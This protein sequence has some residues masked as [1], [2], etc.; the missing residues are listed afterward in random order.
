MWQKQIEW[1]ILK[2]RLIGNII[3]F[4]GLF[5]S[6][7]SKAA[8]G[9]ITGLYIETNGWQLVLTVQGKSTNGTY[10]FGIT[11]VSNYFTPTNP[12]VSL[13]YTKQGFLTNAVATTYNKTN[14][15]T[16][17]QRK[18]Y[19]DTSAKDEVLSGTNV[20]LRL[21]LEGFVFAGDSNITANILGGFY[22][23]GG[24]SNNPVAGITV[25]NLSTLTYPKPI[26]NWSEYPFKLF[27]NTNTAV[28]PLVAFSHE[29]ENGQPFL[30]VHFWALDQSNDSSPTNIITQATIRSV[31]DALPIV[32][33]VGNIDISSLT[34]GDTLT[35]HARV[36]PKYGDL[37]AI[38]DSSDG[39]FSFPA[40]E[41]AP[42]KIV[43][44]RTGA[45]GRTVAVVATNGN[46]VT[47]VVVAIGSFNT[48][49]PPNAFATVRGA[50]SAAILTNFLLYSRADIGG[51]SI[52]VR[53]GNYAWAGGTLVFT[54]APATW[55][56][57]D[58][59]PGESPIFNSASGTRNLGDKTLIGNVIFSSTTTATIDDIGYLAF[60]GTTFTNVTDTRLIDNATNVYVTRSLV[61]SLPQGLLPSSISYNSNFRLARGNTLNLDNEVIWPT[62]VI[63]NS[64]FTNATGAVKIDASV[65]ES[66]TT[67]EHPSYPIMAFNALLGQNQGSGGH[68]V[69]LWDPTSKYKNTNGFAIVQ[70]IVETINGNVNGPRNF[71]FASSSDQTPDTNA[72]TRA[73]IWH[74]T[75][76]GQRANLLENA[77]GNVESEWINAQRELHSMLNNMFEQAATKNDRNYFPATNSLRTGQWSFGHGVGSSGNIDLDPNGMDNGDW[78]FDFYGLKSYPTTNSANPGIFAWPKFIDRKASNSDGVNTAG[79]G[80]YRLQDD[81][82]LIGLPLRWVLSYDL[83]GNPRTSTRN[84]SGAFTSPIADPTDFIYVAITGNDSTGNGSISLP[85]RTV[86]K[87]VDVAIAGKTV[88]VLPGNY[89]EYVVTKASGTTNSPI[90]ITSQN[91]YAARVKQ[92][93]INNHQYITISGFQVATPSD[94]NVAHIRVEPSAHNFV[95]T[96]NLIG[97][98]AYILTTQT[99][100]HSGS[101]AVVVAD[102]NFTTAGFNP[103]SLLFLGSSGLSPYWFTNHDTART[104]TSISTDGK[105]AVVSGTI[106]N[107]PGSN[108]WSFLYPGSNNDGYSGI[109][110]VPGSGIAAP[111]NGLIVNNVLTNIAGAAIRGTGDNILITGN[112]ITKIPSFY[113]LVWNGRNS[114]ISSNTW[115]QNHNV[116]YYT[117]AELNQLVHPEGGEWF[118][119]QVSHLSSYTGDA[120]TNNLFYRNWVEDIENQLGITQYSSTTNFGY[121]VR[122]NVFIGSASQWSISRNNFELNGNIFIRGGYDEGRSTAAAFGGTGLQIQTGVIITN[123][124]FVNI[125]DH[126]NTN[127]EGS[128]SIV[129]AT[130]HVITNN[131]ATA[132]E[133]MGYNG[134]NYGAVSNWF[135]VNGGDPLFYNIRNPLGEDGLPFTDDDGIRV[136]PGSPL[137]LLSVGAMSPY[138]TTNYFPISHFKVTS[139]VTWQ[140]LTGTNYNLVWA[141]NAPFLRASPIRPYTTPEALGAVP[142]T[143][144]FNASN[145]F[146][147]LLTLT[148]AYGIAYYNWQFGDGASAVTASPVV[149]HTYLTTGE[150][151]VTLTVTNLY[152]NISSSSN[153]YR[154]LPKVV[155]NNVYFVSTV[156]NDTNPGTFVSPFRTI[157]RAQDVVEPGG[158]VGV[159]AGSYGEDTDFDKVASNTNRITFVSL[160]AKTS[161]AQFRQP[162]YTWEGFEMDGTNAAFSG[163]IYL[164]QTCDDTIIRNCVITGLTNVTPVIFAQPS[165]SVLPQDGQ[166]NCIIE[167]NYLSDNKGVQF[168]IQGLNSI[169]RGNIVKNTSGEGDFVR[170]WGMG[171][172]IQGNYATNLNQSGGGHADFMQAFGDFGHWCK[173]II[174]ERNFVDGFISQVCQFEMNS[175]ANYNYTNQLSFTN[176]IVRNNIFAGLAYAA[177]VDM[178]GSK[179]YNNT[180]YRVNNTNAS[181]I[182]AMGGPK[183][184]A[185]GTEWK[186]NVFSESGNQSA[187]GLGWYPQ[188]GDAGVTNWSFSA[189]YNYVAGTNNIAKTGFSEANGVNGGDAGF[190]DV[191][192]KDLRPNMSSVLGNAGTTLTGFATDFMQQSRPQ[193]SSWEIGAFETPD[194]SESPAASGIGRA[195]IRRILNL[196]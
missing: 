107:D 151:T 139:T 30:A 135:A 96:N 157:G 61:W 95:I 10:N 47:G 4:T 175:T 70:N 41:F 132:A 11:D 67:V 116:L 194:S 38:L 46:D 127:Q 108:Y 109:L 178:D 48:N 73:I 12:T 126:S 68:F 43:N 86:Q 179:W 15:A 140:D 79:F 117:G 196:K 128:I 88:I 177:N 58:S 148:N 138:V 34:Q 124:A 168:E 57:V 144:T 2:S 156:G 190:V 19:P 62:T 24:S 54:N 104:I 125:G 82:P 92:F 170:P 145:T 123:N 187:S 154:I 93:R 105:L 153:I 77:G 106:T 166:L 130:G 150:M 78:R 18:H 110:L 143:A 171:H 1:L 6:N 152:G 65:F 100:F 60:D 147:G 159:L 64:R 76:V 129:Q 173:D 87:G 84:A 74:N 29:S 137:R 16:W 32:E 51:T 52:K 14:I 176:L 17:W 174:V 121:Y 155:T 185:Y 183:G 172:L 9:D 91:T 7:I 162:G 85:Y 90:T 75:S 181:H 195:N 169:L 22:T 71:S 142:V 136:L 192:Y 101:N 89:D 119:Y 3:I 81:S 98:G 20:I 120:G 53:N 182:F 26:A 40:N 165:G 141:T 27:S 118:D 49:S 44:D 83:D 167:N 55:A 80:N 23:Q 36:I 186:N 193:G 37:N 31:G 112:K 122:S 184:S 134:V 113:G 50:A 180:F 45:Y 39:R 5:I 13:V 102:S 131:F 111:T 69:N 189:N 133:T 72:A 97:P 115:L 28:V 158:Y 99:S 160:G 149:T 146:S 35:V 191:I 164:Y 94:L 21:A 59:Y 114:I 56:S 8:V 63:G 161:R 103:G 66:S 163:A 42:T 25:T 33:A 188:V